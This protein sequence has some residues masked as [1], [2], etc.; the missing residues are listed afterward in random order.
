MF[1]ESGRELV[2]LVKYVGDLEV[3]ANA[4]RVSTR[5]DVAQSRLENRSVNI[6]MNALKIIDLMHAFTRITARSRN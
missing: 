4:A 6:Y 1:K 2:I 3:E 5:T